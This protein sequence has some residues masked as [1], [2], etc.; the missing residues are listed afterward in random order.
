VIKKM[1]HI[2]GYV[3]LTLIVVFC[4]ALYRNWFQLVIPLRAW[5]HEIAHPISPARLRPDL[6][7][8]TD[9]CLS[10]AWIGHATCLIN[11][12]GTWILTDPVFS[13]RVGIEIP[14]LGVLGTRRLTKP[15]L[16]MEEL[17]QLDLVMISHAYMDHF[18]LPTLRKLP[19]EATLITP[20]GVSD[21]VKELSFER[22]VE[23]EWDREMEI[24][25]VS[26]LAFAPQHWGS[27]TPWDESERGYNSYL[28]S[29][30][31][32]T[33]LFAGDTAY[34]SVFEEVAKRRPIDV[35]VFDLGAYLP[36]SFKRNHATSEQ[37]WAMFK[38]TGAPVL[39]P[40]HWGTFINSL[41]TLEDPMN[42]LRA[43]A[44][45]EFYD[46]VGLRFQGEV[47]RTD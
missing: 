9:D 17:P 42:W 10:I 20:T 13:D 43:A 16:S 33:V 3:S 15:A 23:A 47:W 21:L 2:L 37:V 25:G 19:P 46:K 26:I 8:M 6:S 28:L 34:T 12:H 1:L 7:I 32:K 35:A 4:L 27:R 30:G 18:D 22:V 40:I 45:D 24:D 11:F 36:E 31:G 39:I 38:Q 44:G 41:E 5:A 14:V 29:K